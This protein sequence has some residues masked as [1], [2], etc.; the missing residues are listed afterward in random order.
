LPDGIE[1]IGIAKAVEAARRANLAIV[2]AGAWSHEGFDRSSLALPGSQDRLIKAVAQANPRTIVVLQSGGPVLMPWIHDVAAVVEA[3][4]PGEEGGGAIAGIVAGDINPSGK[5]PITFPAS[6]VQIPASTPQQY[7]GIDN[8]E[9][10]S[11][12]LSVG[13]RW[14]D[15]EKQIPLFPFGFGLSYTHFE[16]TKL[17]L[18]LRPDGGVVASTIITNHGK[19]A[20]NEVAQLYVGYPKDT[21]EPPHQ[22]RAFSKVQLESG[23]S[24]QIRFNLDPRAFSYWSVA[25]HS[26]KIAA[27]SYVISVGDSSRDLYLHQSVI[28]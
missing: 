18:T 23:E 28:R 17:S 9:H 7:P 25:K 22:L 20:G 14:Y 19:R 10:Y 13:Y 16:F 6:D 12:G 24:K 26:W 27:G 2:F 21:D 5:L 8:V 4:F 11:E 1:E 3:W 15:T